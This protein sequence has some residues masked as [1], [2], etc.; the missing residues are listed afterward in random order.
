VKG[1]EIRGLVK[2]FGD[3]PV[4]AGLDL[5]VPP[6]SLAAI[7][8]PSGSGKTT[9]LRV[10]AG[11]EEADGGTVAIGDDVVDDGTHRVAP[12]HRNIGYVPQEGALFPHLTVGRNV[13]FGVSKAERRSGM[14]GD[15]LELVGMRG[16]GRRY[17]HQLSGGQQQRVALARALAVRPGLVLLDEPFSSLDPGLR[18]SV[19]ADVRDVLSRTGATALLVTHDQDEALSWADHVAVIRGGRIGQFGTPGDL[20]ERPVD[21]G[22]ATFVGD[23]NLID[24]VVGGAG[25]RT[26]V[27]DLTVTGPSPAE[28]GRPVVVL[29]RPEQLAILADPAGAPVTGRVIG[30]QYFG[31]DAVVTVRPDGECGAPSLVVRTAGTQEWRVGTEVGIVGRGPVVAWPAPAPVPSTLPTAPPRSVRPTSE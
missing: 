29:V 30:Y 16:M 4:L 5:S 26:A 6:G 23:A 8:G 31:H 27:G 19:R 15:L 17:P 10:I 2:S 7:L 22:L 12:E 13:A 25:V 24:G 14:I 20:Y 18:A 3:Q 28:A 1:L 11:F 9:L 21:P